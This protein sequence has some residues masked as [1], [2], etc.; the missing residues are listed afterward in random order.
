MN[1][2]FD[3]SKS[4]RNKKKHGI[5]FKE[6]QNLWKDPF[7]IEIPSKFVEEKRTLMIARL[8]NVLWAAVITYR[9]HIIRIIS[10][11]KARKNEKKI[12]FRGRI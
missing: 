6:A 3:P 1:F 9:D 4:S 8:N 12:Y 10:V 7:R 2:Q 11:R 5:D